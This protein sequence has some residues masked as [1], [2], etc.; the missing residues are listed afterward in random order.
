MALLG[1]ELG[2]N[3]VHAGLACGKF[4][5]VRR[6]RLA[7][8]QRVPVGNAAGVEV[9]QRGFHSGQ[10]IHDTAPAAAAVG[11]ALKRAKLA[12]CVSLSQA[13][14][15]IELR[16][17]KRLG[18]GIGIFNVPQ[19]EPALIGITEE[20]LAPD[21]FGVYA[22]GQGLDGWVIKFRQRAQCSV[23][24]DSIKRNVWIIRWCST[25]VTGRLSSPTE[26]WMHPPNNPIIL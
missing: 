22:L 13:A 6:L 8:I 4:A 18:L 3:A 16:L 1:S 14:E 20:R 23:G 21:Q 5:I 24:V 19:L 26:P 11:C 10:I 15:L 17:A 12:K 2:G 25:T 9:A 7:K